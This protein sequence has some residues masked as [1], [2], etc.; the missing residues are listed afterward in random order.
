MQRAVAS[1]N[2]VE[3]NPESSRLALRGELVVAFR[4]MRVV[5]SPCFVGEPSGRV[6]DG[7]GVVLDAGNALGCLRVWWEEGCDQTLWTRANRGE[8]DVVTTCD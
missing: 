1:R 6:C 3:D 7:P 4:G 2:D 8:Y 5:K